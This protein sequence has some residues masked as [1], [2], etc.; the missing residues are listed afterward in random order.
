[1]MLSMNGPDWFVLLGLL[2]AVALCGCLASWGLSHA[3]AVGGKQSVGPAAA[4]VDWVPAALCVLVAMILGQ[5]TL[6]VTLIYATSLAAVTVI[7]GGALLFAPDA[8][9]SAGVQPSVPPSSMLSLGLPMAMLVW[10]IGFSGNITPASSLALLIAA[11][12]ALDAWAHDK[13]N[14]AAGPITGR[15]VPGSYSFRLIEAG[16]ALALGLGGA[17]TA[18]AFTRE[19]AVAFTRA[20][21]NPLLRISPELLV[22]MPLAPLLL[23][24]LFSRAARQARGGRPTSSVALA[25]GV[26]VLN[27]GVLLP[28]TAVMR[29]LVPPLLS[30]TEAGATTAPATMAAVAAVVEFNP[31]MSLLGIPL[32]LWRLDNM[33]LVLVALAMFGVRIGYYSPSRRMG[34]ALLLLYAG[35]FMMTIVMRLA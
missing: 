32:L 4:L 27:M 17:W 24:P 5:P 25:L 34:M 6:A 16:I 21:A 3:L 1:M 23:L 22:V 29:H 15:T 28:I 7:L 26:V 10:L 14:P 35:Y 19:A 13:P 20:A 31:H 9:H 2:A 8:E 33:L 30:L 18:V 11:L 12:A